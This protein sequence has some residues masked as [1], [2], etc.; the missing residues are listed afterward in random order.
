MAGYWRR[1]E[2]TAHAFTADGWLRTGDVG[3]MDG[4]GEL[5][6][7]DRKKDMINVSGFN[8]FPNEVEEVA[9]LHPG[10][11]EAAAIGVPDDKC[12]E[13]VRLFVVRRDR[14]LT[15][16]QMAAF[17]RERL[18]GYKRPRSIVF[19][20]ALPKTPVGKVLRRELRERGGA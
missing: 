5:R 4:K 13:A 15:E 8:V 19:V 18:T 11:S 2:E 6:I 1:P 9:T 10:V 17:L 12:G 20:D 7:V 16:A 3:V 14:A